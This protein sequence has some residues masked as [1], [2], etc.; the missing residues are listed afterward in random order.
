MAGRRTARCS[1][2]LE[3][4]SRAFTSAPWSSSCPAISV[5]PFS[6]AQCRTGR[7]VT[8]SAPAAG[9]G[10]QSQR[11]GEPERAIRF[12]SCNVYRNFP[13]LGQPA[14]LELRS[15]TCRSSRWRSW[16]PWTRRWTCSAP[17]PGCRQSWRRRLHP[18]LP[19]CGRD[20]AWGFPLLA[21]ARAAGIPALECRL[22]GER[23]PAEM[24]ALALR[25]EA[26]PGAYRWSEKLAMLGYARSRG[27]DL[28]DLAELIEGRPT[29][30]WSKGWRDSPPCPRL[31]RAGGGGRPGPAHRLRPAGPAGASLPRRRPRSPSA[32]AGPSWACCA[33]PA[34]SR[35]AAL[36]AARAALAGPRPLEAL[37]ELAFPALADLRRSWAAL[38]ESILGGSGVSLKPPDFFEGERLEVRFS[39]RSREGL[40]RRLAALARLEARFDEL[41]PFLR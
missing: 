6:A 12:I 7:T 24:L 17:R 22:L 3:K 27:F 5:R 2:V 10:Q 29:R 11:G 38:E 32:S 1:G 25:L 15:T 23:T 20:L 19:V 30:V 21:A 16:K 37:G 31:G 34:W 13:A 8:V 40:A 41:D 36:A 14:R 39:F 35:E 26:R 28:G 33:I 4:L 18:P 9:R